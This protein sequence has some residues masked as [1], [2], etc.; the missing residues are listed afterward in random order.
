[1]RTLWRKLFRTIVSTKGQF[2]A[3]LSVIAVGIT[4]YVAMTA[5]SENLIHSKDLFYA[6]TSFADHFFHVVNAPEGIG[7]RIKAVKGVLAA[8]ARTQKD[9]PVLWRERKGPTCA[10]LV[11]PCLT[12]ES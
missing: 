6:E 12:M 7:E 10:L 4:L 9:V 1:M 5:V 2:F 3:V 8:T 11:I